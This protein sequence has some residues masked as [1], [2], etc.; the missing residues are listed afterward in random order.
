MEVN[1][2]AVACPSSD[3]DV[4]AAAFKSTLHLKGVTWDQLPVSTSRTPHFV[5]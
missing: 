4:E 5:H 1:T 3:R 2:D